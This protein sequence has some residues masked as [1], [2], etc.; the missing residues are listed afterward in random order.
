MRIN[1]KALHLLIIIN[2]I[3]GALYATIK[4]FSTPR[5]DMFTRRLYAYEVWIIIGFFSLY[6]GLTVINRHR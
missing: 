3:T 2:F 6:L 4:T 1:P 5:A